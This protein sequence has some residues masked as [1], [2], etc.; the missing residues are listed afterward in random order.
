MARNIGISATREDAKKEFPEVSMDL[1]RFEQA[2]LKKGYNIEHEKALVCP[3]ASSANNSALPDCRNCGGI[4]YFYIERVKTKALMQGFKRQPEYNKNYTETDN[5]SIK[6]TT[7]AKDDVSYM[8]KVKNLDLM[9]NFSQIIHLMMDEDENFFSFLIYEPFSVRFV[10]LF[11]DSREKLRLLSKNDYV[12]EKNKIILNKGVLEGV[13]YP[14]LSIRYKHHPVYYVSSIERELFG[15]ESKELFTCDDGEFK[16][17]PQLSTAKRLHYLWEEMNH[18]QENDV[19][20]D[21][22]PNGFY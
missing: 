13:D 15:D 5:T 7:L 8:D 18:R 1:N 2:I 12:V 14:T 16:Q 10:Y 6:L 22:T 17:A 11:V 4:G 3:C 20:F 21:N 9:S 19:F